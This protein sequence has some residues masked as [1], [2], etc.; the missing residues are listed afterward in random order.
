MRAHAIAFLF[1]ALV[2][3]CGDPA[4]TGASGS[5]SVKKSGA[6]SASAKASTMVATSA[7]S[8]APVAESAAP[9]M[10]GAPS[11]SAAASAE[12]AAGGDENEGTGEGFDSAEA[13]AK[14]IVATMGE[15]KADDIKK[16][17]PTD[18][19]LDKV[20]TCT[21]AK[22]A[23]KVGV[24]EKV[25]KALK[26]K[27]PEGGPFTFVSVEDKLDGKEMK[28]GEKNG[29]CELKEDVAKHK[30]TIKMKN[31]DGK[32]ESATVDAMVGAGKWFVND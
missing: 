4:P 5:A 11:A 9:T 17:Y 32:E 20:M 23:P 16:A 12:P 13:L 10:S 1:A 28:K 27:A 14:H 31:K 8:A 30:L 29:S 21:D 6:A 22:E 19:F 24:H 18:E 7:K 3:G 25:G 2:V 15:M 26:E